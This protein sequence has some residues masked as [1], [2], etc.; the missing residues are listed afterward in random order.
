MFCG[1]VLKCTWQW[2]GC[3]KSQSRLPVGRRR[4]KAL[5]IKEFSS[6]K[7]GRP[8]KNNNDVKNKHNGK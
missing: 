1:S 7:K 5:G 2:T 6:L 3:V 4:F 8:Q